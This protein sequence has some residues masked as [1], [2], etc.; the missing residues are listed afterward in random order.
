M[1][2]V[3]LDT[4]TT[5]IDPGSG[6]RII[7]IGA[8]EIVNRRIT[9]RTF[10]EYLNPDRDIDEGAVAVH[11]I[12]REDLEG[13]P[14][15]GEIV[16][17]FLAFVDGAELVIHNAPFDVGFIDHELTLI[18]HDRRSI[19]AGC[20][21]LDTLPL[22]RDMHPGQRNSL[23]AL[24]RRYDVDNSKRDLHGALLDAN[25]LALVY[26][27]MTGGQATLILEADNDTAAGAAAA[28]RR[29]VRGRDAELKL[30]DV[31][32]DEA[33]RHEALLAKI[34]SQSGGIVSWE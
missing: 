30:I 23:D 2:Q 31:S 26:L 22:A 19:E 14:R 3:A 25:L 16:D 9:G 4:E 17:D 10:H 32:A 6:H 27:A 28:G 34:A 33:E 24:C 20:R 21:V 5:G 11:G 29:S 8:A 1:R 12:R 13:K 18:E 15:F 7:E